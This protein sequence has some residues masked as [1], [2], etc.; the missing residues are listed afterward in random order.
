VD[1]SVH[2][3]VTP[4]QSGKQTRRFC[5]LFEHVTFALQFWWP[6]RGSG[7]SIARLLVA[8][9]GPTILIR[10]HWRTYRDAT[11]THVAVDVFHHGLFNPPERPY[12][13]PARSGVGRAK[14]VL[15]RQRSVSM[16][17][18]TSGTDASGGPSRAIADSR[19]N[20]ATQIHKTRIE[21]IRG[22]VCEEKHTHTE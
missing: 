13:L 14:K 2:S 15:H 6:R 11:A 1:G 20:A 12:S 17:A 22:V 16:L 5:L 10:Q 8:H 3:F 7:I 4:F 21:N 18:T 19:R 9:P